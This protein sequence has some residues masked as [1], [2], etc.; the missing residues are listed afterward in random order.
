MSPPPAAA[1]PAAGPGTPASDSWS[2]AE[3]N[4]LRAQAWQLLVELIAS[5]PSFPSSPEWHHESV[6]FAKPPSGP[7]AGV[8][9][10]GMPGELFEH[11]EPM[12]FSADDE[13]KVYEG[14][15]FNTAAVRHIQ[16]AHLYDPLTTFVLLDQKRR[17]ID[18]FPETARVIKT[19]WR[20]IRVAECAKVGVWKWNLPDN[21]ERILEYRW[22]ERTN[23][24]P[25]LVAAD[26]TPQP[27]CVAAS[28]AFVTTQVTDPKLY[29][30]PGCPPLERGQT[31]V[32]LGVHIITKQRPDWVWSTFWWQGV[33]R[34]DGTT[35]TASGMPKTPS[36]TCDNAQRPPALRRDALGEPHQ[37]W[38]NYSMDVIVSHKKM[39]P[40]V[41]AEDIGPCG[42]PGRL[43]ADEQLL[44]SYN[45]F[46]EGVRLNGRKSNC[47]DCHGR[48]T[49]FKDV[50]RGVHNIGVRDAYPGLRDFEGHIRTDYLWTVRSHLER[51]PQK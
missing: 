27:G 41:A 19:F 22:Q 49:T 7:P 30:C 45:P 50:F 32:L 8:V 9:R 17:E 44:A 28:T 4:E 14:T 46:V 10:F 16:R 31:M 18:E 33:D 34:S 40:P 48:P 25:V 20:P 26:D 43:G 21:A 39:K 24:K 5:A 36:W 42:Q 35:M 37:A 38:S 3:M 11:D 47:L 23:I 13:F 1:A 15:F 6:A 12:P 2:I 29:D 51:T